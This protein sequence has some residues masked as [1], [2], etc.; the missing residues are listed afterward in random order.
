MV[1]F[2]KLHASKS[3]SVVIDPIEIFRRLPSPPDF[4]DLSHGLRSLVTL[5]NGLQLITANTIPVGEIGP[6]GK[7]G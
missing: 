5:T 1:D 3:K 4:F 2:K 6:G 7:G